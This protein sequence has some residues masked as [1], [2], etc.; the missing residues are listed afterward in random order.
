[1]G[2]TTT[3]K[4]TTLAG[5]SEW[6]DIVIDGEIPFLAGAGKIS[7]LVQLTALLLISRASDLSGWAPVTAKYLAG[8]AGVTVDYAEDVLMDGWDRGLWDRKEDPDDHR[9]LLY[10]LTPERWP[11]APDYVKPAGKGGAL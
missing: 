9:R 6:D 2:A 10:R 11:G 7:G 8:A 3:T 1:V 5:V 4:T